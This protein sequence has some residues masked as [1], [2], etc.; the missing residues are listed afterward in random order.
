[1]SNLISKHITIL[2]NDIQELINKIEKSYSLDLFQLKE[3]KKEE[4]KNSILKLNELSQIE[5][6][7]KNKKE[8]E[9]IT[10]TID[11]LEYQKVK[12][13]PDRNNIILNIKE[14]RIKA[15]DNYNLLKQI[16][17][18]YLKIDPI[19]FP[20]FLFFD[21]TIINKYGLCEFIIPNKTQENFSFN[22]KNW[23]EN[24][25]DNGKLY[26]NLY[27]KIINEIEIKKQRH[28]LFELEIYFDKYINDTFTES[29]KLSFNESKQFLQEYLDCNIKTK[30]VKEKYKIIVNS[31][32]LLVIETN[33]FLHSWLSIK[34]NCDI[35][36][37]NFTT[38]EIDMTLKFMSDTFNEKLLQYK[39]IK[40]SVKNNIKFIS[41]TKNNLQLELYEYLFKKPII[42]QKQISKFSTQ[43]WSSLTDIEKNDRFE[44]F[45]NYFVD[46]YLISSDLLESN[47]KD[48]TIQFLIN[49]LKNCNLKSKNIKWNSKN[50][51]IDKITTLQWNPI[52][53]I[54]FIQP[55]VKPIEIEKEKLEY[56]TV[57]PE[58]IK[59][60]S[61][62][63]TIMTK[64]N[65]K[66]IN[67]EIIKYILIKK[68]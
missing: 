25:F 27:D 21:K 35:P 63:K 48:T 9:K 23:L 32:S 65:E 45:S 12:N 30:K 39:E 37:N 47:L 58:K 33:L 28:L 64:Q 55:D 44:S 17:Q 43:K 66:I 38:K 50:G 22:R 7:E 2:K 42:I 8:I 40:E 56:T 54:L 11:N 24:T 68:Q 15:K 5:N 26:H 53:Q 67:E 20:A 31:I 6:E 14:K 52:E 3:L 1:M 46:K 60:I 36:I 29:Q 51:V 62:V 13:N 41:N 61:S 49:L 18:D 57:V 59:K 4:L 19:E 34:Y 16:E 10:R